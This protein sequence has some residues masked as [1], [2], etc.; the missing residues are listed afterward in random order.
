MCKIFR[1]Y[2][3]YLNNLNF[4]IISLYFYILLISQFLLNYIVKMVILFF[5][6]PFNSLNV[7]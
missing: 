4:R 5:K 7:I 3:K 2:I 1:C 6:G